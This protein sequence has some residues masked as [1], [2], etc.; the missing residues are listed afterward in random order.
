MEVFMQS[1]CQECGAIT[2]D[3]AS[4]DHC[5]AVVGDSDQP[6][7]A[8]FPLQFFVDFMRYVARR[9]S[10][11]NVITYDDLSW[12]TRERY[13][14]DYRQE[15][16][17]WKAKTAISSEMRNKV[18]ILLQHDV[19]SRAERSMEVLRHQEELGLRSNSM[20]F[21]ERIDRKKLKH[22]RV[23]ETTEYLVDHDYLTALS[24]KG[25]VV[26]YHSN[27]MER[28][29][30]NHDTART[31]FS[32]DVATLRQRYDIRYFSPHG[33]VPGP[34]GENNSSIIVPESLQ[35]LIWVHNKN[36][37]SFKAT[38][39]DGGINNKS[40]D[41]EARNLI[42]FVRRFKPGERYRIL[43][44]PQYYD[45]TYREAPVLIGSAWYREVLEHYRETPRVS[46]WEKALG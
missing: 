37:A 35:D 46:L 8:Y 19:D 24:A 14:S 9:P 1:V 44:H 32:D 11:F 41:P 38:Y 42:E 21:A 25:W 13:P 26:G 23:V 12:S 6:R 16:L 43:T 15:Y 4:C 5:G 2:A 39:S 30:F 18:H 7:G 10:E 33:G 22:E 3:K 45:P 36:S 27:A 34:N 31:L 17:R 20:I 40:R 29:L 28:A